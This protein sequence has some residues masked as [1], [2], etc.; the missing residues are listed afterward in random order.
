MEPEKLVRQ[1][2]LEQKGKAVRIA[3]V[4]RDHRPS[5]QRPEKKS[6]RGRT[7]LRGKDRY[8]ATRKK[9]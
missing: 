1:R 3:H 4:G 6:A 5:K 2:N 7:N 9:L 8:Q